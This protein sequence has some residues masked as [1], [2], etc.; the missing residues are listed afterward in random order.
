MSATHTWDFFASL[1]GY[2]ANTGDWGVNRV[3]MASFTRAPAP[4]G[5]GSRWTY[6]SK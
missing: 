2:G 3:L 5:N 4:C 1:D 6:S